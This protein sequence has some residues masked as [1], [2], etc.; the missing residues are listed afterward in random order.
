MR[1]FMIRTHHPDIIWVLKSKGMRLAVKIACVGER[2]SACRILVVK[3]EGET[4]W[5]TQ[6]Q[7]GI[8]LK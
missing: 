2:R 7:M 8:L 4:T 5:K 1:T 3:A 6:V